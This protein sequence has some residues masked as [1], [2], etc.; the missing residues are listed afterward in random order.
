MN[1]TR[2]YNLGEIGKPYESIEIT[3]TEGTLQEQIVALD[4]AYKQYLATIKAGVV[5]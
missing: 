1:I 3:I 5:R 4:Q 2:K